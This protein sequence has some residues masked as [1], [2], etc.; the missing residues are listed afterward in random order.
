MGHTLTHTHTHTHPC[1]HKY[2]HARTHTGDETIK[3]FRPW[4]L[5]GATDSWDTY[6]SD[7]V[8]PLSVKFALVFFQTLSHEDVK[9]S[10]M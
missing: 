1:A 10:Y 8:D 7:F 3:F 4:E 5:S 9:P 6:D 2:P